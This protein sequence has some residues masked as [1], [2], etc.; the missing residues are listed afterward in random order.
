MLLLVAAAVAD[1]TL[2]PLLG[3]VGGKSGDSGENGLWLRYTW[4]FGEHKP[5]E[6]E[7]LASRL[8][9]GG[10]RYAYFHV[11]YAQHDG[12]LH[13]RYPHRATALNNA[14]HSL[15]PGTK[16][17]AWVYVG[18]RHGLGGVDLNDLKTRQNLVAEAVWLVDKCGFDGVQWDYEICQDGDPG[19]LTLLEESRRTLPRGSL[20]CVAAP[21][22][23]PP[24]VSGYGWSERY[25]GQVAARCD[26]I[27]VMDYDTGAYFPRAY[28]WLTKQQALR[29]PRAAHRT[30]PACQVLIGL[31]TYEGGTASHNPRAENLRLGLKGVREASSGRTAGVALFADYTTSDSEWATYRSLWRR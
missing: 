26:Q 13:F 23:L 21:I 10:F 1:Y 3:S 8:Q 4:Y 30:N 29:V 27:A 15:S 20:L 6:V 31:P 19:F 17:I 22:W 9:Q 25:F 5:A 12:R 14:L 11:R 7:A 18:N 2:Y 16:S 24:P 28:V